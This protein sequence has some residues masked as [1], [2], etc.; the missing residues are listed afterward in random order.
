MPYVNSSYRTENYQLLRPVLENGL[1]ALRVDLNDVQVE[2]FTSK[3]QHIMH[4]HWSRY[5]NN[6]YRFYWKLTG[7]CYANPSFP[8]LT[9]VSRALHLVA[10]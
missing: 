9:K 6:A 3:E 8:Q 5:L 10:R 2:L 4:L 1:V 7:L